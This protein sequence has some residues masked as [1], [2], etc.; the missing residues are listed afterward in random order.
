MAGEA[1]QTWLIDL[2][3]QVTEVKVVVGVVMMRV[4]IMGVIIMA[5]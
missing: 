4:I 2:M 1:N 3:A 5:W